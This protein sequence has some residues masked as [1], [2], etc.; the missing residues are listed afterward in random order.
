MKYDQ[1]NSVELTTCFFLHNR[2]SASTL[3]VLLPFAAGA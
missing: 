3:S 2:K 1:M